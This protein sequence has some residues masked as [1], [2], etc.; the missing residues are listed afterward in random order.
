M[1]ASEED[2]EKK[3]PAAVEPAS[4]SSVPAY[5]ENQE[6]DIEGG[7]LKRNL[8]GRHMQMI[9]IGMK[10]LNIGVDHHVAHSIFKQVVLLVPVFSS[11]Q[12]VPCEREVLALWYVFQID[13]QPTIMTDTLHQA[14]RL[15]DCRWH[16]SHDYSSPGRISSPL[17][18]KWCFLHILCPVYQSR[19]VGSALLEH[20][21]SCYANHSCDT[22][23]L[24]WVGITQ[25]TGLSSFL[26]NSQPPVLRSNTGVTI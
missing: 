18:A 23:V 26:S 5:G 14:P 7:T 12:E 3:V 22:G 1:T 15:S 25:L 6:A 9:A 21:S 19:M 8:K 11:V 24:P 20:C 2:F 16:A 13:D 10:L 17:S 4:D